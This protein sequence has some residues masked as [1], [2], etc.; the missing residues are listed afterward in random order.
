VR[1]KPELMNPVVRA[2]IE[3]ASKLDA[4][5]TFKAEYRRQQLQQQSR[6]LF[7][8]IDCLL[9]PT[10]GALFTLQQLQEEPIKRNSELGYYT[11]FMNLLDLAAIAIPAGFTKA[12]LPF[13]VTL[14]G[15]TFADFELLAIAHRL[16]SHSPITEGATG[17]QWKPAALAHSGNGYVPVAVCGAHLSGMALNHQLLSRKARL[18][19]ETRSAPH[20]RLYALSG[21]PPFRPG[22][23]RVADNGAAIIVEVWEMPTATV[24]SFLAGIGQPL[25]LGKIELENGQWVTAFICEGHAVATATDITDFGGWRAYMASRA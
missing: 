23:I 3:P 22:M 11:N 25:G 6:P 17:E 13:G 14:I 5:S 2:I 1:K 20:Y 15:N 19:Q 7:E 21:G 9:L 24:G 10:A 8:D 16:L 12:Q 4:V 18:L